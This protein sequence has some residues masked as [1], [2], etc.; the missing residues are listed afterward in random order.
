VI[1]EIR[2]EKESSS[3]VIKEQVQKRR[4]VRS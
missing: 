4:T 3:K 1:M 2:K